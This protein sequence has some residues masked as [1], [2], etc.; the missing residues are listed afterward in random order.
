MDRSVLAVDRPRSRSL[1]SDSAHRLRQRRRRWDRQRRLDEV[2]A[3]SVDTLSPGFI[4]QGPAPLSRPSPPPLWR[5]QKG[6][7][8]LRVSHSPT[9]SPLPLSSYSSFRTCFFTNHLTTF[10]ASLFARLIYSRD[11]SAPALSYLAVEPLSPADAS[12]SPSCPY[13]ALCSQV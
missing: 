2:I 8:L 11:R 12:P 13:R 1:S 7:P 4:S 3:D 6:T 9:Q 5:T 10:A